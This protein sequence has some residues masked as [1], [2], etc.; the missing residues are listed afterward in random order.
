MR[1]AQTEGGRYIKVL[2]PQEEGMVGR[3][4]KEIQ[5]RK[6]SDAS[7]NQ[8]LDNQSNQIGVL[9]SQVDSMTI[10]YAEISNIL[11][12]MFPENEPI[13]VIEKPLE[14]NGSV[15]ATTFI[16]TETDN[17]PFSVA[18]QGLNKN[19]NAEFIN[20]KSLD[21]LEDIMD[22]KVLALDTTLSGRMDDAKEQADKDYAPMSHVNAGGP[23][24]HPYATELEA[25]FM[26]PEDK[27]KCN[28]IDLPGGI[29]ASYEAPQTPLDK[30]LWIDMN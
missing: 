8:S 13:A 29:V 27:Q 16:S 1:I 10:R 7:T 19:L 2:S 18:S 14:V 20:S 23:G 5:D 4:Y 17:P 6:A 30:Q 21:D 22:E 24:V 26:S 11:S 3:L 9:S 12:R 28:R 25:G 15:K